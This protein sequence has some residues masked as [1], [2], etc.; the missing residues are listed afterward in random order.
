MKRA[1][2]YTESPEWLINKEATINP[3]NKK[4]IINAFSI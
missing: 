4:K 1:E 3:K 2:S